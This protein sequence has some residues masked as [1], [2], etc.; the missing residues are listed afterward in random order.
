M[1]E[2]IEAK[3]PGPVYRL[4]VPTVV[5]AAAVG[6]SVGLVDV[7]A[8]FAALVTVIL[9]LSISATILLRR[10]L[11]R[12]EEEL[13]VVRGQLAIHEEDAGDA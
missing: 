7:V 4:V 13:E 10:D 12:L 2:E 3:S 6:M 5:F 1:E 11:H 8:D 9:V